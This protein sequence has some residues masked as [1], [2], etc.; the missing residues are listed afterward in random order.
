MNDRY[1]SIA[2][3]EENEVNVPTSSSSS[4]TSQHH[5]SHRSSR[6]EDEEYRKRRRSRYSE[7][8]ERRHKRRR[9]DS[10]SSHHRS[11]H[12]SSSSRH[13][14]GSHRG[15][16]SYKHR[17]H[18]SHHESDSREREHRHRRD[19]P[20]SSPSPSPHRSSSHDNSEASN[21]NA[22]QDDNHLIVGAR[23]KRTVSI[24]R[25]PFA[26]EESHVHEFLSSAGKVRDVQ[27]IRDK[28]TGKSKGVGIAEFY[29]EAS[30]FP[31][32][33]LNG[34]VLL[35]SP[36]VIKV[37]EA[38]KN[39][40]ANTQTQSQAITKLYVGNIPDPLDEEDLRLLFRAFGSIVSTVIRRDKEGKS[41]HY[42]FVTFK[43]PE[44]ARKALIKINGLS[45]GGN[46]RLSVGLWNESKA[47]DNQTVTEL[48]S[49]SKYSL[50]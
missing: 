14:S 42:G 11:S 15:Y 13:R 28:L 26:A 36:V 33:A 45:L 24:S 34:K 5:S 19:S 29:D 27:L 20:Y 12:S 46:Y 4:S 40:S 18:Y 31:A 17:S 2:R 22:S 44:H 9:Y 8:P 21:S 43:K 38:E 7:S 47:F 50:F 39:V 41:L 25:L 35:G 10:P 32:L 48:D 3:E 49:E 30:I 6:E 16:D 23:E 1:V 37:S